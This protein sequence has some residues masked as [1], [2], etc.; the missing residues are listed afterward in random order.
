MYVH[1]ISVERFQVRF[2]GDKQ[3]RKAIVLV[4]RYG[5]LRVSDL[6]SFC[7]PPP[8]PYTGEAARDAGSERQGLRSVV[9]RGG[10]GTVLLLSR[11]QW[12]GRHAGQRRVP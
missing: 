9:L 2:L 11:V 12:L 4:C 7:P 10:R 6:R 5:G 3:L 1:Y 8:P